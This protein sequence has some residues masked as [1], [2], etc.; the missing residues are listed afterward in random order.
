MKIR[1]VGAELSH[2]HGRTDRQP[3]T[4]KLTVVFFLAILRTR[5]KIKLRNF[6]SCILQM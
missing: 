3:N 4:M 5:R 1:R 6:W 2:A